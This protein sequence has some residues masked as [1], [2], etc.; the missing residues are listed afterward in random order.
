MWKNG[1]TGIMPFWNGEGEKKFSL[2]YAGLRFLCGKQ[3]YVSKLDVF[4]VD[5]AQKKKMVENI[6]TMW[7]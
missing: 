4:F 5:R 7:L 1:K 3:E 2:T 6:E